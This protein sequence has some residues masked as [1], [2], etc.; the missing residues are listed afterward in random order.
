LPI[1]GF[2]PFGSQ[3]TS[4]I[5]LALSFAPRPCNRFAFV[6]DEEAAGLIN[7]TSR[8]LEKY[9][10]QFPADKYVAL[11]RPFGL[12]NFQADARAS[13]LYIET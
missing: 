9:I 2:H 7:A 6:E 1:F 5:P 4:G 8:Q 12:P 13:Y 3:T 11:G 10:R